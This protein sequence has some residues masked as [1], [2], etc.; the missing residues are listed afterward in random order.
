MPGFCLH[1]ALLL[2]ICIFLPT[3]LSPNAKLL[4]NAPCSPLP[5][6][7][8]DYRPRDLRRREMGAT[9]DMLRCGLKGAREKAHEILSLFSHQL[10]PPLHL[11][12]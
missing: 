4:A 5:L 7:P 12:L 11:F 9:F 8:L 6:S 2:L 10:S 1:L 3:K